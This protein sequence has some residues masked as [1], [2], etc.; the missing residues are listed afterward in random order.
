M[1]DPKKI[2]VYP[3]TFDPI[4]NGH[5]D[6]ID[7]ALGLF[8][9]VI[10]A[11]A[12]NQ[13]KKPLFDFQERF[14]LVEQALLPPSNGAQSKYHNK[15]LVKKFDGL[16]TDFLKKLNL[17]IVI[18]GLRAVSDFEYE[19]SLAGMNRK[20]MPEIETVYLMPSDEYM[21]VSSTFVRE[22]ATLNGDVAKFVPKV[23]S[24]ALELKKNSGLKS[25]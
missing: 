18:R 2:A 6:I 8:D 7:R 9:Q 19:F 11:V 5:M 20:L 23:V 4:T 22:V 24:D 3:G 16:L 10:V 17:N 15:I 13:N 25:S 14:S 21:F 1:S 12:D